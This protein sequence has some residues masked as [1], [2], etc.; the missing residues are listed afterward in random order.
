MREGGERSKFALPLALSGAV[1]V[2]LL[3]SVFI[4]RPPPPPPA[5][6]TFRVTMMAAP[7]GQRAIG[8]VRPPAATPPPVEAATPPPPSV[9]T[10]P[11]PTSPTTTK[12]PPPR[13]PPAATTP[14]TAPPVPTPPP[15]TAP[16]AGGGP[17]GGRGADVANVRIDGIEFQLPGY[18]QNIVRQVR[19]RFEAPNPRAGHSA[20]VSFLID[21]QGRVRGARIVR[22][23]GNFLFDQ[24]ALGSIEA[25]DRA[26]GFGPLPAEFPDDVLPVFFSF[27]PR[28]IGR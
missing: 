24:E 21:R 27:D 23:S 14:T 28:L 12:A 8:V 15:T 4:F 13:Q 9:V 7:A 20:E 2:A 11:T 5:P 1:H 22:P 17:A 25:V 6:P 10:R 3:A 16:T 18:L 26:G 19:L